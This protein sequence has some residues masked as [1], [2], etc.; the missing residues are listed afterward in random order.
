MVTGVI[1]MILA[2]FLPIGILGEMV[3]IGTL[4]A[5]TLV[6][7]GIWRLRHT[8]PDRPRPF[9]TPLVPFVPIMGVI[10]CLV[11]MTSLPLMTWLRLLIW[12]AIG[13]GVYFAYGIKHS[14]QHANVETEAADAA[15]V[16]QEGNA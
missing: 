1:A 6:C 8:Q 7:I 14:T 5:F 15:A 13:M 4:L 9:K 16:G 12:M 10:I 2:G 11:Q 3:S